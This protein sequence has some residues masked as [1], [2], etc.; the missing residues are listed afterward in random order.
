MN[1]LPES[2]QARLQE[3]AQKFA[4]DLPDTMRE[5]RALADQ[6]SVG[7]R[8]SLRELRLRVHRIGGNAATFG[9]EELSAIARVTEGEIE[10]DLAQ[11][12]HG[13]SSR[14][15]SV[16]EKLY[17]AAAHPAHRQEHHRTDDSSVQ[18]DRVVILV[19]DV[20]G[21]PQD[22]ADQVAVFRFAV[23]RV[24][25]AEQLKDFCDARLGGGECVYRHAAILA[26]VDHFEIGR[27][28]V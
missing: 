27:A 13:I 15:A 8:E 4:A 22:F 16:L 21:L 1:S 18:H 11:D 28:H 19:G 12:V 3:L 10:R 5:I 23:A 25:I 14:T 2:V 20:P 9:Y 17:S 24:E 7:K 6:A 26:A